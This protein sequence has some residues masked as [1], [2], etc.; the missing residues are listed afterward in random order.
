MY[1][2]SNSSSDLNGAP[3]N[4]YF[5]ADTD[6]A[7]TVGGA[8]T[9]LAEEIATGS[10]YAFV[11]V[12][13]SATDRQFYLDTISGTKGISA[14]S[15]TLT[16]PLTEIRIG[17]HPTAGLNFPGLMAEMALWD[18]ELTTEQITSFLAKNVAT[19][20]AAANLRGYWPLNVNSTS[21]PNL[22]LDSGGDLTASSNTYSADHPAITSTSGAKR[23]LLMGVG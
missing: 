21:Q 10:W 5:N 1:S 6:F 9:A 3:A 22:G 17:S 12:Y 23:M 15:R 19:G 14:T 18:V 4:M 20:I 8:G 16:T 2:L 11:G 7:A 13:R